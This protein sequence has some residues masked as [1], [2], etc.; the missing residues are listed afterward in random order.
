MFAVQSDN[1]Q[2]ICRDASCGIKSL[3]IVHVLDMEKYP[4]SVSHIPLGSAS[5]DMSDGEGV[6]FHIQ[7][8]DNG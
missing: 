7:N 4:L 1:T 2:N 8:M 3:P 5:W 6:F